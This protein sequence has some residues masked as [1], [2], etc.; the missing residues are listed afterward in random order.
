MLPVGR[1]VG[2]SR[3][4]GGAHALGQ[5]AHV[6]VSGSPDSIQPDSLM[7][8][9]NGVLPGDVKVRQIT[10]AP[11]GEGQVP[12]PAHWMGCWCQPCPC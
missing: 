2:A 8:Y 6:D 9:L 10:V 11:E 1:V 4:D 7:M 12:A 5:V 3:T